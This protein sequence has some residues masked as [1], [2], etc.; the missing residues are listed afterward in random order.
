VSLYFHNARGKRSLTGC[1]RSQVETSLSPTELLAELKAIETA[2]GRT[3]ILEKGPRNIDLDIVLY[4]EEIV[5]LDHLSIPHK[6]IRERDFVLRPICEQVTPIP[7]RRKLDLIIL[8]LYQT[9]FFL[10]KVLSLLSASCSE[11]CP[12]PLLNYLHLPRLVQTSPLSSL[13]VLHDLPI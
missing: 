11:L 12:T 6:G 2:L 13:R 8:V 1:R 10:L 7:S 9:P 5:E 4:G 3:K